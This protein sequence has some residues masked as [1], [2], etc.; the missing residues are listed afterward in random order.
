[1]GPSKDDFSRFEPLAMAP[2]LPV[3]R[4][5]KVTIWEVSE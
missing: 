2:I 1:M 4:A 5:K 3:S